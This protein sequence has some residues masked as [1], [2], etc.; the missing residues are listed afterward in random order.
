MGQ[1]EEL[2]AGNRCCAD[3]TELIATAQVSSIHA[4]LTWIAT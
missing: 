1:P 2:R 4:R 3:R